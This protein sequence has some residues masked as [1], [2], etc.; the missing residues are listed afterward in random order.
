MT[1]QPTEAVI[2]GSK[3]F[4]LALLAPLTERVGTRPRIAADPAQALKL[5]GGAGLVVVEFQGER[6]LEAI[7][8]LLE[9]AAGLSVIA[10]VPGAHAAAEEALR[11]LGVESARWDGDPAELLS[12]VSRRLAGEPPAEAVPS[13]AHPDPFAVAA[14][15]PVPP[16]PSGVG[17]LFDDM[18]LDE[19]PDAFPVDVADVFP[20][21]GADPGGDW[22]ANVPAAVEAADALGQGLQ[23]VFAPAGAP[24]A[25]VA[26]VLGGLSPLER[27]VIVG[28]PQAID[29][30][31]IRRAA[32]MRV[33]VA[34]ALATAPKAAGAAPVDAG[35]VSALLAEIDGLLT[36]VNALVGAAPAEL[37]PS[38]EEVRNGLVKEA[39]DFSEAAHRAQ[40]TETP[41]LAAA[42]AQAAS[43]ARKAAQTRV[44]SVVSRAE[45]EA[46][47]EQD[48][49]HRAL[50]AVL[51]VAA[52]LTA[53]YHGYGWWQEHRVDP[54]QSVVVAGAPADTGTMAPPVPAGVVVPVMVF[55]RDGKPFSP[56]ELKR[57]EEHQASLGK[58]VREVS[59]GVVEIVPAIPG[60][61]QAR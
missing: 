34:A 21:R 4:A 54:D 59:P 40:P 48:K 8:Q 35:A 13:P 56:E 6:S 17:A 10:A 24:L 58:T 27:A 2:A 33:R 3:G 22:P 43:I 25:V 30:E 37:Q 29:V 19:A 5:T 51:A 36:D 45:Q 57:L 39:I 18:A 31:P 26:D 28:E 14:P 12:A 60:N 38:L 52:M 7:R 49:R 47:A 16:A 9:R 46:A 44:L 53:A 20:G 61:P 1:N 41:A 50:Y 15:P 42:A 55:A 32:V 23:G 11:S